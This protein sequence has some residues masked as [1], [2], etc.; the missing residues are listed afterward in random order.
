MHFSGRRGYRD[1]RE[2]RVSAH[3][4]GLSAEVTGGVRAERGLAF[5]NRDWSNPT[6][7]PTETKVESGTSQSKSG[8]S[9]NLSN[10][11]NPT[12]KRDW[13]NP[14]FLPTETK[15]ESGTSQSKSGT[16]VNLSNSG[17]PTKKRDWS[18]PTF[19]V[20]SGGGE[21]KKGKTW[22]ATR[23]E[24]A[25]KVEQPL[26]RNVQRFR[27]GLVFKAHRLLPPRYST[28]RPTEVPRLQETALP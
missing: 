17:N 19:F 16:S 12:K 13:S 5:P 26:Y 2:R 25:A 28:R 8:T 1:P 21:G 27:G 14:T 9:V 7:L 4:T 6:F 22:S 11:G 18:N 3:P 20:Q 23:T 15:V 10:S 24:W